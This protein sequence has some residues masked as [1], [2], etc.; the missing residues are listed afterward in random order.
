MSFPV[1]PSIL[2]PSIHLS[3]PTILP[4]FIS[5]FLLSIHSSIHSLNKYFARIST[6]SYHQPLN[7]LRNP[8][9]SQRCWRLNSRLG[10]Q[11]VNVSA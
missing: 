6:V 7:C 1:C 10:Y 2:H 9:T 4:S 8:K 3:F 11:E 5:P